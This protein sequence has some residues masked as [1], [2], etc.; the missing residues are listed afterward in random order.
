MM[1]LLVAPGSAVAGTMGAMTI[2]LLVLTGLVIVLTSG[3]RAA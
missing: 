3:R 2:G 1:M